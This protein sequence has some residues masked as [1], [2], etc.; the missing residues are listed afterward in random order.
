MYLKLQNS[1][2]MK[3]FFKMVFA[4]TLGVLFAFMLV[5]CL[6]FFLVIG[7]V[8]SV[9]SSSKANYIPKSEENIFKIKLGGPI[10]DSVEDNPFSV[11]LGNTQ[12]LSLKD[13]LTAIERAKDV[14]TIKGIYLDIDVFSTGVSSLDAIRRALIDFKESGK[15]IV[16]YADTYTQGGYYLA[17]VADSIYLNP[18]G[19]LGIMG[20]ASQTM[21]YQ[22]LLQKIGVEMMVFKVGTYKGAVEPFIAD[23]LSDANREQITAYQ[24]CIWD[25]VTQGIASSRNISVW[26]VNHFADEGLFLADPSKAVECGLI[27]GLKYRKEVEQI[28]MAK[29]GQTGEQ[30]QSLTVSKVNRIKETTREYLNKIAVIYAEGEITDE[31]VPSPYNSARN[32]ITEQ[33]TKELRKLKEEDN[34]KAVVIRVNSP[35]GSAFVSEQIWKDVYDLNKEKPVVISM[36]DVAA[37]GG[38]YISSAASKIVAEANTLTGSIGIFGIFPNMAGL[39][40]KL[41]LTTDIVKTNTYADLGDVS[42]SMTDE[43][44]ALIQASVERG[45]ELFLSRCAEG[46]GMSKEAINAIGQ[47]RVWTGEQAVEIGLVDELGGI[48]RAIEVAAESAGIYNYTL[49][50]VSTTQDFFQEFMQKQIDEIKISMVKDVM[51]EEYGY[52]KTLYQIRNTYG[53]QAR[54]PYDLKP[55]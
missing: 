8:A 19:V 11:F 34:V 45:Y 35:G 21:F 26:D 29:V 55:L 52:L 47:G 18:Q 22:G 51:G 4:S 31:L 16:A 7:I 49:I 17:S 20:Y 2:D 39:F 5:L 3:Q 46:R 6:S 54:I 48:D 13:I 27:D 30:I 32:V 41:D 1:I 44:K 14:N 53:I 24:R 38:Y 25:N 37:S 33:M 36:G 9:N 28:L 15:F 42:R 40:D 50:N 23:R 12:G 10:Y 43:E